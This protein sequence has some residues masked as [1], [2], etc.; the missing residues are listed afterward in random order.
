VAIGED[1]ER[2]QA[3]RRLGPDDG[4]P[5]LAGQVVPEPAGSLR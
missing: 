4:S 3:E 2:D 1:G 5:D